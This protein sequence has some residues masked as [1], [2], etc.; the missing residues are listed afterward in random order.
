M[1]G[2]AR[3]YR[4]VADGY[5]GAGADRDATYSGASEFMGMCMRCF[6]EAPALRKRATGGYEDSRGNLVL[7]PVVED[8]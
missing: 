4:C 3:R 7:E 1:V 6:G 8:C 2:E 5:H